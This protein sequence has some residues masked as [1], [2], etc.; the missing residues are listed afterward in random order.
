MGVEIL[1]RMGARLGYLTEPNSEYYDPYHGS[2]TMR[3]N[4]LGRKGNNPDRQ[5]RSLSAPKS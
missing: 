2:K 3:D 5:L 4:L 1:N